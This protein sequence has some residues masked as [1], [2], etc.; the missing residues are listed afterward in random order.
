[1]LYTIIEPYERIEKSLSNP[2]LS[3]KQRETLKKFDNMLISIIKP[4]TRS[5]YLFSLKDFGVYLKGKPFEKATIEDVRGFF[6]QLVKE[7]K[8]NNTDNICFFNQKNHAFSEDGQ[9]IRRDTNA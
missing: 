9:G 6:A 7:G 4:T 8:T 3:D 5:G 1:M 2:G